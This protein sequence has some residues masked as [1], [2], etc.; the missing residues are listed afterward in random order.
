MTSPAPGTIVLTFDNLGEA[1]EL[2]RGTWR[3]DRAL[4][5]HPS[6]TVALPRLLDELDA[7]RLVATFCV[8]AINCELY[9]AAIREIADRGHELAVHGWR[10]ES[11][12]ALDGDRERELLDRAGAAFARAALV[13]RP[14]G[15]RPPGGALTARTPELL[16]ARGYTW[17]SAAGDVPALHGELASIPF[18]WEQVDAYHLMDSFAAA[19]RRRG[20][21]PDGVAAAAL[22][23]RMIAGLDRPRPVHT[24]ILHPFLMLDPAWWDG[25]REL[26]G[27]VAQRA[28]S[29]TAPT[30]TGARYA[31]LLRA[32]P[33]AVAPSPGG[34]RAPGSA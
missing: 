34:Q 18:D 17:C 4:G 29:G 11:W 20:D 26:L 7:L 13:P 1:T 30:V 31:E 25:V 2:E 14:T 3:A 28:R 16:R 24:L 9:P 23:R 22:A 27:A 21:P 32:I 10:H 12:A 8:E 15:F 5:T 6:V 19:R 33:V